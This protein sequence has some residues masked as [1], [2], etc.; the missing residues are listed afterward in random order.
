MIISI[1]S[2]KAFHKVQHTFM[3]KKKNCPE[4]GHRWNYL[5]IIKA[6]FDKSVA[7]MTLSGGK[8]KAFPSRSGTRQGCPISPL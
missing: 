7:N 6:I 3:I 5:N 2:G 8:L 4:S 1:D